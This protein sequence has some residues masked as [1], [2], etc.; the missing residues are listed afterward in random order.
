M[1]IIL[2][3]SPG[4]GKDTQAAK[5]VKK[6]SLSLFSAGDLAREIAKKDT[7]LS[8]LVNSGK[9]IPEEEMTQYVVRHLEKTNSFNN[10]LFEGYPRFIN[11]YI[12]L[13]NLLNKKGSRIDY[14]ISLDI[15]QETAV[16]RISSRRICKNCGRVFNLVTNPPVHPD[17]CD[18]CGK[19]L[20]T[21]PDDNPESIKTRFEYYTKNTEKLTD[22]LEK[23][24]D[25]IRINGERSI[26][27][28]FKDIT[29]KIK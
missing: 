16:K 28:I 11:Q 23:R 17:V 21:R 10:I 12:V 18:N 20:T 19:K 5:L 8:K 15:S 3:G 9:L 6:Y 26:D 14:T 13:E 2:L 29:E 24:G 1:N 4:S 22:Y 7:R 27:E 25:L